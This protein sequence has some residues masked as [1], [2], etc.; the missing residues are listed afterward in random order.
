MPQDP[1]G[2]QYAGLMRTNETPLA[3][4]ARQVLHQIVRAAIENQALP[5]TSIEGTKQPTRRSGDALTSYLVREAARAASSL[6]AEVATQAFL[7]SVAIGLD[8]SVTPA[9]LPGMAGV[10]RT[11]E[12][13][14]ERQMRL[15]V[16]GK[17]TVR[18]RIDLPQH[19]FCAAFLTAT[20]GADATQNGALDAELVDAQRP[21]GFSFKDVAADRAGARF[22]R[23][24]VEKRFTLKAL[25]SS[26]D[27]ASY[28]PPIDKLP[29]GISAKDLTEKFGVK[30]DPRFK[31]QLQDIDQSVL[32]LP[33]YLTTG[34]VFGP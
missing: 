10:V 6:P 16:L 17:P 9:K 18:N 27:I 34:A 29:D 13:D 7:L 15:A 25:A 24:L 32:V 28:M 19:F 23:S 12:T 20:N 14:S 33:G 26:F 22:G 5:T 21:I 30:S 31:K 1:A 4:A 8:S 2:F 11:V 3:V